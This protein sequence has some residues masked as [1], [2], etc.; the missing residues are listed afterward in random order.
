MTPLEPAF[1]DLLKVAHPGLT[2][3][4]IDEYEG[5]TS[6]AYLVDPQKDA[7]L[8]DVIHKKREKILSERMP[9]YR[10]VKSQYLQTAK[11]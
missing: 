4:D 3:E 6:Q 8:I 5:L 9:K 7:D 2:D 11:K 10:E 1:R